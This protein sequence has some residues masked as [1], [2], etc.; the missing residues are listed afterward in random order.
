MLIHEFVEGHIGA[1]EFKLIYL[2]LYMNDP[3]LWP[4]EYFQCWKQCFAASMTTQRI[5][6]YGRAPEGSTRP[7]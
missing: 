7:K 4:D 3:T 5:R 2:A 6:S 1:Q